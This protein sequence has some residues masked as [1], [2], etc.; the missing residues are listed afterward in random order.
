MSTAVRPVIGRTPPTSIVDVGDSVRVWATDI[1]SAN[2]VASVVATIIPAELQTA[3][4]RRRE[5]EALR[6]TGEASTAGPAGDGS[7]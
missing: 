6:M 2:G 5:E 4:E 1:A 7:A 3:V